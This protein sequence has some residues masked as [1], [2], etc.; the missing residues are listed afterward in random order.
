M[1]GLFVSAL[2]VVLLASVT[3][4]GRQSDESPYVQS[5]RL[6]SIV[7]GQGMYS[8]AH[9]PVDRRLYAA[10]EQGLFWADLAEPDGRLKGPLLRK[11]ITSIEVAP[12]TGR[13]F[14]TTMDEVGMMKLRSNDPPV[15]LSGREWKTARWAYEPTRRQMYLP[16]REGRVLVFDAETGERSP[17][18]VVPGEFVNMLEAVPG[19]VFFSLNNKNGLFAIDAETKQVE[20]W[21]VAGKLVTPAYLDADPTGRY[22][23]ATYDRYVLAIDVARA[24]V[25]GRLVTAAGGRI[26]FDPERRLLIASQYDEPGHPRLRLA[27]YRVSDDGFTEVARLKNPPDGENG[28]ESLRG[29]GFLQSGHL[30]LLVWQLAENN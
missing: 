30:S 20:P 5:I 4:A 13:L 2:G 10:S 21:D 15:R 26:A 1:K 12:D 24:E 11:R 14:Y 8:F 17:D 7:N 28:L 3:T 19:R 16:T 23:F 25:V 29:G 27:A 6:P 22:L 18:V 9:D